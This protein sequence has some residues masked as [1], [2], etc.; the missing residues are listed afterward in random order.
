MPFQIRRPITTVHP[1][2]L[3]RCCAALCLILGA[4][5]P[6][7][8]A[9]VIDQQQP[10]IDGAV[11]GLAIGGTS[12]QKLAQVVTAGMSGYLTEVRLPVACDA[13][14]NLILEIQDV[15]AGEPNGVVLTSQ[16]VSGTSLPP[17][18]PA[19]PGFR[20]LELSTP[21]SLTA[22][23]QFAI[24]LRS[25]GSCGI[26]RG[27]VGDSYG[28][29]NLYF[30]A[31]PNLSGWVCVC[32]F[33]GDRFDLPFQTLVDP[34]CGP[35]T[36]SSLSASP[37]RLWPANHRMVDVTLNYDVAATCPSS[38]TV[39][40]ASSEAPNGVGDGNTTPDW[41]VV[42][43]YHVRLRAERAG[44]RAGRIYTVTV[45]CTTSTGQ[46]SMRNVVVTVPHDAGR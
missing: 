9:S 36:V 42:D 43:P 29:G 30:D 6:A 19:P 18:F 45:A 8:A 13:G 20:G 2:S 25:A 23:T 40:V 12:T 21:V 22:G 15:T 26:F 10:I 33:A 16:T 1:L 34:V 32:G 27:P 41:A 35:L 4:S 46:L 28:A 7:Q 11:G 31:L 44:N 24:V 3:A 38:C 14:S 5:G 39:S 17:F 37:S